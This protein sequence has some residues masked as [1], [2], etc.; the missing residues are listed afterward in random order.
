MDHEKFK[1]LF[2]PYKEALG[3]SVD[4]NLTQWTDLKEKVDKIRAEKEE[5]KRLEEEKKRQEEE[6]KRLE[7]ER[8]EEE[9]AKRFREQGFTDFFKALKKVGYTKYIG[10]PT[11]IQKMRA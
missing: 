1:Q 8:L 4:P 9:K 3:I 5:K 2:E 6:E 7:A 11:K 10:Q